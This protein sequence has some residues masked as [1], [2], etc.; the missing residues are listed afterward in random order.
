MNQSDQRGDGRTGIVEAQPPKTETDPESASSET[1]P[2]ADGT[3]SPAE[4]KPVGV[5]PVAGLRLNSLRLG[6]V[7]SPVRSPTASPMPAAKESESQAPTQKAEVE[8]SLAKTPAGPVSL[9]DLAGMGESLNEID[10]EEEDSIPL[11][12]VPVTAPDRQLP[13][14]LTKQQEQFVKSLDSIYSLHNDPDMFVDMVRK[15]MS[16][17]QSNPDLVEL[18]ADE[19][20]QAMISGLRQQ[21]GMAQ[22]KKQ[23]SK[24]KRGTG[25]GKSSSSKTASAIDSVAASLA[26]FSGL[27]LD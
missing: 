7:A 1:T 6:G 11:D 2:L 15:I 16:E 19:D 25:N 18:L 8:S 14:E 26:A 22:V 27:S 3:P 4:S 13:P 10:P 17:M 9:V 20:S 12:H 24:K 23:E 5:R 21:A